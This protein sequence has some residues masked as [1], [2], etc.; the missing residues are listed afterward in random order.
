MTSAQK[1]SVSQKAVRKTLGHYRSQMEVC[2]L[3]LVESSLNPTR[4]Q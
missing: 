1:V 3:N 4:P 2:H